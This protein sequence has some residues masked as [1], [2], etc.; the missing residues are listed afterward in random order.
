MIARHLGTEGQ[1]EKR[2]GSP[3]SS[4]VRRRSPMNQGS[5]GRGSGGRR[6]QTG[7]SLID[8]LVPVLVLPGILI[9]L[10]ALGLV[11]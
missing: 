7:V 2:L 1:T 4:A 6:T 3:G 10:Y 8:R 5:G 11:R 9:L